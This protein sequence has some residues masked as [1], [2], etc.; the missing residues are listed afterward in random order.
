MRL[1]V[2]DLSNSAGVVI[3]AIRCVKWRLERGE[4]GPLLAPS[5]YYMKSPPRQLR[6]S[7]AL[8]ACDAFIDGVISLF[9]SR[10]ATQ[11]SGQSRSLECGAAVIPDLRKTCVCASSTRGRIADER[12][13]RNLLFDFG[14]T[15]DANGVA[16][17]ERFYG[18]YRAEGLEMTRRSLRAWFLRRRFFAGRKFATRNR[19]FGNGACAGCQSRSRAERAAAELRQARTAPMDAP[20]A[21][22]VRA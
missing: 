13:D 3:D 18:F 16:W 4:A 19:S 15:L 1:S 8:E 9:Q 10:K 14:G 21:I 20:T 7:V 12:A 22:A 5:A 17:K 2:E 11:C 6:D